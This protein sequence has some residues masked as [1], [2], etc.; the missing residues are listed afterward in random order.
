MIVETSEFMT[1]LLLKVEEPS[2]KEED[3]SI[4]AV[5]VYCL[6]GAGWSFWRCS[7]VN[8]MFRRQFRDLELVVLLGVQVLLPARMDAKLCRGRGASPPEAAVACD[9]LSDVCF[10]KVVSLCGAKALPLNQLQSLLD[11]FSSESF[12]TSRSAQSMRVD[13]VGMIVL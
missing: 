7:R 11:S 3:A 4:S 9:A 10:L 1:V 12:S 2:N 8:G 6:L 13:V 5:V